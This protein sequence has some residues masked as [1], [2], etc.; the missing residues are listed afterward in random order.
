MFFIVGPAQ[1]MSGLKLNL[2][3]ISEEIDY[4]EINNP[5]RTSLVAQR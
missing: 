2:G 3:V 5:H 4:K 1:E